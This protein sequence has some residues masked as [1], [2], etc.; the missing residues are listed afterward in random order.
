MHGVASEICGRIGGEMAQGA[1]SA[2]AKTTLRG[3]HRTQARRRDEAERKILVA[4]E[5]IVAEFGFDRL[6]LAQVGERAGCSRGLPSHYFPT[7]DD[8]LSALGRYIVES[9][10]ARREARTQGVTG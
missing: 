8:L 1:R 3:E 2:V 5:E 9:Y 10:N 7:K 4:A 6:T